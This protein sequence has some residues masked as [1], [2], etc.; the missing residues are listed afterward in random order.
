MKERKFLL[1]GIL[2]QIPGLPI[3]KGSCEKFISL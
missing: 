3:P 2:E 1:K